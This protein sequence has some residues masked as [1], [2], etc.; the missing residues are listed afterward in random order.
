MVCRFVAMLGS[1]TVL[2]ACGRDASTGRCPSAPVAARAGRRRAAG[3]GARSSTASFATR[4]S[5]PLRDRGARRAGPARAEPAH[6]DRAG[7]RSRPEGDAGVQPG[8]RRVP[9]R[10]DSAVVAIAGTPPTPSCRR[11]YR[12][13]HA[14]VEF[15]GA[16]PISVEPLRAATRS[17]SRSAVREGDGPAFERRARRRCARSSGGDA[18][19]GS[20][21]SSTPSPA[22]RQPRGTGTTRGARWSRS[23]SRSSRALA[24]AA[25]RLVP[26]PRHPRQGVPM[27]L[28][29]V[30]AATASWSV[31]FQ[32]GW[33]EAA[34][35]NRTAA[36]SW[37][38][39][40][41][42]VILF[43][44]RWTTACH[45]SRR[46]G[47]RRGLDTEHA[48]AKGIKSTAASS[49]RRGRHGARLRRL[50]A[51]LRS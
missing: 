39:M 22:T 19:D 2:P 49:Q 38:P 48:V 1:L 5:P 47:L 23:C 11:R 25:A 16:Q 14:A 17:G 21:G 6:G 50:R 18:R 9:G 33:G 46:P 42:F 43:G 37:L 35:F 32:W 34:D 45:P 44:S 27:N 10:C 26:L 8:R 7:F 40:L 31:T 41:V 51:T 36:S 15:G 24:S 12:A 13:P 28:L 3:P 4:S 20:A 30:A 29:S